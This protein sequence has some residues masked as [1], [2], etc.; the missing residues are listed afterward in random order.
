MACHQQ[1]Y[2]LGCFGPQ[3]PLPRTEE[4]LQRIL[5]LPLHPYLSEGQ[6][7]AFWEG[8]GPL[9]AE[10]CAMGQEAG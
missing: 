3:P 7:D 8:F 5:S 9:L 10:A 2:I 6:V 1:P 4:R